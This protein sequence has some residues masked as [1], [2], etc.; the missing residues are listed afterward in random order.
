MKIFHFCGKI[1][2][3][4]EL[5]PIHPKLPRY[6]ELSVNSRKYR[7]TRHFRDTRILAPALQ[8]HTTKLKYAFSNDIL[9]CMYIPIGL[10]VSLITVWKWYEQI[11]VF[12]WGNG[13][14]PRI[15]FFISAIDSLS[16]H[17]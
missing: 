16:T 3:L 11:S 7:R 15:C 6:C 2:P 4:Y 8:E 13:V 1:V 12:V 10:D 9:E 5:E 17:Q 14:L